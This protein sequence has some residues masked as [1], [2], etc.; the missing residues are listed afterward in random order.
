[1]ILTARRQ[2]QHVVQPHLGLLHLNYCKVLVLALGAA[3]LIPNNGN[4]SSYGMENAK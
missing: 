2:V 1:M 3:S 4:C